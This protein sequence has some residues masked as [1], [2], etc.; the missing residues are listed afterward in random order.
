MSKK[1]VI[2]TIIICIVIAIVFDCLIEVPNKWADG[3]I[4][5]CA[6]ATGIIVVSYFS[7]R[8]QKK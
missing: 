3:V 5:G 6:I 4:T 7:N 8:S 2:S 1:F